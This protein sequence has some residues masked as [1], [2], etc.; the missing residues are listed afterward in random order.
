MR[1]S[2]IPKWSSRYGEVGRPPYLDFG[3]N[4]PSY[5]YLLSMPLTRQK[6]VDE[7]RLALYKLNREDAGFILVRASVRIITLRPVWLYCYL[8][9]FWMFSPFMMEGLHIYTVRH[10][11][12]SLLGFPIRRRHSN[13]HESQ[14]VTRVR[15]LP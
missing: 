10:R 11:L 3:A 14:L 4:T 8:A 1:C 6:F 7:T 13:E 12:G 5:S 15:L 9:V 2:E